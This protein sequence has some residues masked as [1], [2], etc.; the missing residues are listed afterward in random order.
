[1]AGPPYD[2]SAFKTLMANNNSRPQ[3]VTGYQPA[4]ASYVNAASLGSR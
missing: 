3:G 2:L 4:T 1:M